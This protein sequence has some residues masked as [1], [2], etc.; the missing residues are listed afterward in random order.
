MQD[1][2]Q[3]MTHKKHVSELSLKKQLV[4]LLFIYNNSFSKYEHQLPTIILNAQHYSMCGYFCR[5][6]RRQQN[7]S[8]NDDGGK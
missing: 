6:K 7:V 4:Q 5:K 8:V 3:L 1:A 2:I